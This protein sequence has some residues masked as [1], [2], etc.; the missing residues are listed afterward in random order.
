LVYT[1]EP[2]LEPLHVF[3]APLVVVYASTSASCADIAAKLV[4][5]T[6]GGRAEFC[7]IGIARSTYLFNGNYK[8]DEV[9]RW[10]FQLEPTSTVFAAG[11]Q[12]RLEIAGCAFPLYDRNPSTAIKPSLMSPW[13]W[14][15][16]THIVFHDA[17]RPSLLSLPLIV[18]AAEDVA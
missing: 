18:S 15:R 17:G 10:E 2:L 3:G 8:A 7:C 13:N 12:V 4:R 16:S 6:A 9:Q 14:Q 11:E 1:S 5:V